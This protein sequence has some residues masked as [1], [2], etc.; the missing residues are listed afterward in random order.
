MATARIPP[1]PHL[2]R[3]APQGRIQRSHTVRRTKPG[4]AANRV[5][6]SFRTAR[7]RRPPGQSCNP[8]DLD[9]HQM[10]ALL[11]PPRPFPGPR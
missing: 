7:D 6:R 4:Y 1:P 9:H 8:V 2:Y 5:A 11:N 10:R 3:S